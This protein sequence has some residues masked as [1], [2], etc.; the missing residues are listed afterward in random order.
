[1]IGPVQSFL[2]STT[3]M[4]RRASSVTF[5][6]FL[7]HQS[8]PKSCRISLS[9]RRFMTTAN[10]LFLQQTSPLQ[11]DSNINSNN[12]GV[13]ALY[14]TT[15]SFCSDSDK[16]DKNG[17]GGATSFNKFNIA[18]SSISV[19]D[20]HQ[21]SSRSNVITKMSAAT[22]DNATTNRE[23]LMKKLITGH[24]NNNVPK[25]IA[26]KVGTD[27]HRRENHPLNT[28]KVKIENYFHRRAQ[29]KGKGAELNL[30]CEVHDS[31][32]PVVNIKN[33]FDDLL[34]KPDHVSRSPIDTYYVDDEKVLRTHTSAHQSTYLSQGGKHFLVSGDVYRRD[35]ID[36]THYPV[37]HQMEGV[38]TFEELDHLPREEA[39]K[40]VE[41]DL[42][43]AL[44][45]LVVELFGDCERKWI[46]TYFPFT[47]PSFEME[48]FYNDDWLEV[49]G[50]GVIEQE[51]M[52]ST[53]RGETVGWAFGLGLERL[54]MV[55]FGIPDIRLFWSQDERFI[56]QFKA[57]EIT[58]FVPYSKYPVCYKDVSFWIDQE[59]GFNNNDF[60]E[61]ARDI[62]GDLI[63]SV[64]LVDEFT[65][66][67]TQRS[68]KCF[69]IN[70]RSM[71]RSLTNEE[72]DELQEQIRSK[73]VEDLK[74]ELR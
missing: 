67:K 70:Y 52:Q 45:G 26:D 20:G 30:K 74:V 23:E 21:K 69:R 71:D 54:A 53:G 3:S 16:D 43:D 72:V 57:G 36:R 46:D 25:V 17:K 42:K 18:T 11:Q 1:M 9:K 37:F 35:E 66:P 24:P 19:L 55:L 14:F 50:C 34:V 13:H 44:E 40:I 8:S 58:K 59:K 73:M 15:S 68:S 64:D 10:P 61:I 47:D 60:F 2:T 28:I 62:A 22:E 38:R 27:L 31:E 7:Q 12:N 39:V 32:F 49:F 63:E 51:I 5:K 6:N 48:I 41:A 56:Q 65:H 33:N 4:Q 29:E